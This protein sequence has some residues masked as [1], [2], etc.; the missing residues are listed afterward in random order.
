M[1]GTGDFLRQSISLNC[2]SPCLFVCL[3][4]KGVRQFVLKMPDPL[5]KMFVPMFG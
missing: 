2:L 1:K 4:A 5:L 3:G